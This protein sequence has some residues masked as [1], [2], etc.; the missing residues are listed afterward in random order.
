MKLSFVLFI[1]GLNVEEV[2]V[3]KGVFLLFSHLQSAA[4]GQFVKIMNPGD[5][6]I[7]RLDVAGFQQLFDT[8]MS[9]EFSMER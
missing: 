5:G 9:H 7:D 6:G 4:I 8:E 1:T 3:L 2:H